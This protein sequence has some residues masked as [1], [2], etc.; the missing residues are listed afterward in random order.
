[1]LVL[2][3]RQ[4]HEYVAVS[5]C[6][7]ETMPLTEGET[8]EFENELKRLESLAML[9]ALCISNTQPSGVTLI[10]AWGGGVPDDAGDGQGASEVGGAR[11]VSGC[12]LLEMS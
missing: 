8:G 3:N 9:T 4:R 11:G 7:E 6:K 1:M 12:I 10:A 2:L 5:V